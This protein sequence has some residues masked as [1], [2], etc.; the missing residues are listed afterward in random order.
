MPTQMIAGAQEYYDYT[1]ELDE[2][3]AM[4][5]TAGP[6]Q[7]AVLGA[8]LGGDGGLKGALGGDLQQ[9]G[10]AVCEDV[11]GG[12]P[13][14]VEDQEGLHLIGGGLV[15]GEVLDGLRLGPGGVCDIFYL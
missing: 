11:L 9:A 14:V 13:L 15:G 4:A 2:A 12:L 10:H 5:L 1:K 3:D 6:G 7:A 8:P